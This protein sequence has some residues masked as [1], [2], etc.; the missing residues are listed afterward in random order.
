MK[1]LMVHLRWW[2][3]VVGKG[4]VVM[5]DNARYGIEDRRAARGYLDGLELDRAKLAAVQ[6]ERVRLSLEL[7]TAFGLRREEAIKFRVVYADRRDRIQLKDTWCNGRTRARRR[8]ARTAKG[9]VATTRLPDLEG[10]QDAFGV[11]A[12]QALLDDDCPCPGA[13]RHERLE[14]Q[15]ERVGKP[16]DAAQRPAAGGEDGDVGAVHS[17]HVYTYSIRVSS[18]NARLRS[19]RVRDRSRGDLASVPKPSCRRPADS[20]Q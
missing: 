12:R 7:Q 6:D 19:R 10:G 14:A 1:N 5:K 2:A 9:S 4:S 13:R 20:L 11:V 18:G 3:G 17:V 8:L 16:A 15:D